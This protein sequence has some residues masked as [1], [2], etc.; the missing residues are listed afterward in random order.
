M[1]SELKQEV[2]TNE[3]LI[4]KVGVGNVDIIREWL[5]KQPHLPKISGTCNLNKMRVIDQYFKILGSK[6]NLT[7]ILNTFFLLLNKN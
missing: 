4:A 2:Y 3:E 6:F 7:Y 1:L 5:S